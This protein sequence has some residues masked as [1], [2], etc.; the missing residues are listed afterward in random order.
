MLFKL[1]ADK[2][3][4]W[5]SLDTP[6]SVKVQIMDQDV[7]ITSF[8]VY[9][10][11]HPQQIPIQLMFQ[12]Y[13]IKLILKYK[14]LEYPYQL[15]MEPSNPYLPINIANNIISIQNTNIHKT[16]FRIKYDILPLGLKTAYTQDG[17]LPIK[18]WLPAGKYNIVFQKTVWFWV[19]WM[20]Y[21]KWVQ[22]IEIHT[23]EPKPAKLE[24]DPPEITS[25]APKPITVVTTETT[26]QA[27]TRKINLINHTAKSNNAT[28]ISSPTTTKTTSPIKIT[29]THP[30]PVNMTMPKDVKVIH[31]S[32]GQILLYLGQHHLLIQAQLLDKAYAK[33]NLWQQEELVGRVKMV[34]TD[35][36][37]IIRFPVTMNNSTVNLKLY[38]RS[39]D[40]TE[41]HK[42]NL[43]KKQTITMKP[44]KAYIHIYINQNTVYIPYKVTDKQRMQ[45]FIKKGRESIHE[46]TL[47][48]THKLDKGHYKLQF[49][50]QIIF[51]QEWYT[52]KV[53]TQELAVR[54]KPNILPEQKLIK[55]GNKITIKLPEAHPKRQYGIVANANYINNYDEITK[56]APT[57]TYMASTF[58]IISLI[59]LFVF[60]LIIS[61]YIICHIRRRNRHDVHSAFPL[62]SLF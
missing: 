43:K 25:L 57:T 31:F 51:N 24:R 59:C 39:Y 36:S 47:P 18:L 9:P 15:I 2:V 29:T 14:H 54:Y 10:P 3:T 19:H 60:L 48:L 7:N 23:N 8:T 16:G 5:K 38:Y 33:V 37:K 56:Q 32:G 6:S 49:R 30:K 17:D 50:K 53:W 20:E 45:V 4:I 55:R 28:T 62:V 22:I 27:T 44:K 41:A 42:T 46:G 13:L 52:Y 40:I 58:I 21:A 12:K 11:G 61:S 26:P 35:T 1:Q 34:N